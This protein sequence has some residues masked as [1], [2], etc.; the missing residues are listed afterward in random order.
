M[1]IWIYIFLGLLT[2]SVVLNICIEAKQL[3]NEHNKTKAINEI[4]E[5]YKHQH[6]ES[7]Q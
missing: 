4:V 6:Q 2:I 1:T 5:S 3:I 7:E